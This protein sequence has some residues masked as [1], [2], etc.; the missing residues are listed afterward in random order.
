MIPA[1]KPTRTLDESSIGSMKPSLSVYLNASVNVQDTVGKNN[2]I[3]K[4]ILKDL[5]KIKRISNKRS[6]KCCQK[7]EKLVYFV[8][9]TLRRIHSDHLMQTTVIWV[10]ITLLRLNF[11][12]SRKIMVVS[13]IPGVLFE[14]MSA[15]V[16]S[17]A[18][19]QYASELCFFL[20]SD[21]PDIDPSKLPD[22]KGPIDIPEVSFVDRMSK[23]PSMSLNE[24][25]FMRSIESSFSGP[26]DRGS[27]PFVPYVINDDNINALNAL[28][29]D[30]QDRFDDGRAAQVGS[31]HPLLSSPAKHKR[32]SSQHDD[33]D[34]TVA[35]SDTDG[36]ISIAAIDMLSQS[37]GFDHLDNR[38][39]LGVGIA[40]SKSTNNLFS[41]KKGVHGTGTSHV[42]MKKK[43]VRNAYNSLKERKDHLDKAKAASTIHNDDY[44]HAGQFDMESIG[45]MSMDSIASGLG[46]SVNQRGGGG[47]SVERRHRRGS[48]GSDPQ[49]E[50]SIDSRRG[51]GGLNVL[52]D[53]YLSKPTTTP[54]PVT[55]A[56]STQANVNRFLTSFDPLA[57][58]HPGKSAN[59]VTNVPEPEGGHFHHNITKEMNEDDDSV[60]TR[61][62]DES[63]ESDDDEYKESL[64]SPNKAPP[65]KAKKLRIKAEKL[66][67]HKFTKALFSKKAKVKVLQSLIKRLGD[68]LELVDKDGTGYVT[69]ANFGRVIISLA[70]Q[71]LLRSDIDEFLAA[72]VNHNE[73]LINYKEFIISGKVTIIEKIAGR[74]LLPING[75]LERQ[76]EYVGDAT[77]YTWKNHMMW[78]GNRK[79]TAVV[80]L[81]R[82]ATNALTQE[83]S[84][85][86]AARFLFHKGDQAKAVDGLLDYGWKAVTAYETRSKAKKML[87]ARCMHARRAKIRRDDAFVY[88]RELANKV[89]ETEAI[90]AAKGQEVTYEDVLEPPET[91]CNIATVYSTL[92]N[93]LMGQKWLKGRAK[94]ALEFS[95]AKDD[96][97]AALAIQAKKILTQM[98]LV[99]Q[100]ADWLYQAAE[101]YHAYC[102]VQDNVLLAMLRIGNHALA[103]FDRQAAAL[104]WLLERGAAGEA[105]S[106]A[107]DDAGEHL[108]KLGQFKLNLLNDR[109]N[110]VAYLRKRR[111]NAEA[112]IIN[113][114]EAIA[115]LRNQVRSFEKAGSNVAD[116][117]VWLKKRAAR[118]QIFTDRKQKANKR[119][120]YTGGKAKVVAKRVQFSFIDL[121]QIGNWA[122]VTVFNEKWPKLAGGTNAG[123]IVEELERLQLKRLETRKKRCE[124]LKDKPI[125]ESWKLELKEAYTILANAVFMPGESVNDKKSLLD[126]SREKFLSRV[127]FM[128]LFQD[129]KLL[130]MSKTL[131]LSEWF[132]V[133]PMGKGFVPFDDIWHW[134]VE[135]AMD[136]ER[137]IQLKSKGSKH[138]AFKSEDIYSLRDQALLVFKARFAIQEKKIADGKKPDEDG[139]E[140]EESSDEEEEE[141]EEVDPFANM[142]ELDRV[143]MKLVDQHKTNQV[144]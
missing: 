137:Q 117:S 29:D 33:D 36:S 65:R 66:I 106:N 4:G 142:T 116:S 67:D 5:E 32:R 41:I 48:Y 14:I 2:D 133:D 143:F 70:P 74:S 45:G 100:A 30:Q 134:F 124:D 77:T 68:V 22:M 135:Q 20:C 86:D 113:K 96:A 92:Y 51:V 120:I 107:Q 52:E 79:R 38:K 35:S 132:H 75:W 87:L 18:T 138:F 28:F 3:V 108:V 9:Q 61:S 43:S 42:D 56:A 11:Q 54:K 72:Q 136:I 24:G 139:E 47:I 123:R 1:S 125:E 88:L 25:S 34:S 114:I 27:L 130:N 21:D 84:I 55:P 118:A 37:L 91:Q 10:L 85:L 93:H 62:S 73:D 121:H 141:E 102:C 57:L 76:K 112:L 109:E 110:S 103:Y 71:E 95:K 64:S 49:H 80:W 99:Q 23:Q 60:G 69:W 119:L 122:R 46:G 111:Y 44:D 58:T 129:G 90:L 89:L 13:G 63:L 131:L 39:K 17:G 53:A 115:Y 83:V 126:I 7:I 50:G 94:R 26:D 8:V 97:Q 82:R 98:I 140:E 15:H 31:A 105:H 101:R 12:F 144:D 16:L 127:G 128:K 81:M 6:D 19:R 59:D 104:P 40:G 78:Y